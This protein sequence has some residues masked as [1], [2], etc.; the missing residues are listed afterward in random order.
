MDGIEFFQMPDAECGNVCEMEDKLMPKRLCGGKKAYAAYEV[1]SI[2]SVEK[3]LYGGQEDKVRIGSSHGP[4]FTRG[5][6]WPKGQKPTKE[7][8]K[9]ISYGPV[10]LKDVGHI[11][12]D[13]FM[14]VSTEALWSSSVKGRGD[15]RIMKS[16]GANTVR[17]YGDDPRLDHGK[18][19]DEAMREG[20]QVIVGISDYPYTQA[21]DNCLSTNSNC[22]EQ[23]KA[24]YRMVMRKGFL[25]TGN[26]YHPA[27]RTVILMNE[28]DLKFPEGPSSYVKGIVSALDAVLDVEQEFGVVGSAPS[29]TTTFSFGVC[30]GGCPEM[31][32]KPALGQM[33]YL[34]EAMR[35]PHSVGYEPRN[36]LWK[37]YKERFINSVNTANPA[38]DIRWLF[39]NDYDQQFPDT[40][41]FIGEYHSPRTVDQRRDLESV[42]AIARDNKTMLIG[43]SFFEFQVRYDKGGAEE[44]FGMFGL[45]KKSVADFHIEDEHYDAFC[46]KPVAMK[47]VAQDMWKNQ[48]GS[49]EFGVD[50]ITESTWSRNFDRIPTPEFCC[51]E[52]AKHEECKSWTWVE[53][54]GLGGVGSPAQCWLKGGLPVGKAPKDGVISGIPGA[55][56]DPHITKQALWNQCGG[57]Y[58]DGPTECG[59]GRCVEKNEWYS[60]CLPAEG[61]TKMLSLPG[62]PQEDTKLPNIYVHAALTEAYGGEGVAA[63][64]LCPNFSTTT[65]VTTTRL[66]SKAPATSET[67]SAAP[68]DASSEEGDKE[69]SDEE[70]TAEGAEDADT[71][72]VGKES[73]SKETDVGE[74][75][76]SKE[77]SSTDMSTSTAMA[78]ETSKEEE[79]ERGAS[80]DGE[81]YGCF[82]KI[83]DANVVYSNEQ[84]G[85]DSAA[86]VDGC[87]DFGY[88][89]LH[90][91]G[92]CSCGENGPESSN[93]K[94][95][96]DWLCRPVCA[97]EEGQTPERLCGGFDTFA[98]YTTK[99][100]V[101]LSV[102]LSKKRLA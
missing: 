56:Q 82:K 49:V 94:K 30:G 13:D 88:A 12:D 71:D 84:G 70:A 102:R 96:D 35:D 4:T 89:F 17:L 3:A 7:I 83:Q 45:D 101:E 75:S 1:Q 9:G 65:T 93:F 36:D 50:F 54:A 85:F 25:S 86:C 95:V 60:Q 99:N 97:S 47:D 39:L 28:P 5:G 18:F 46:L 38:T 10:P 98:V 61:D 2:A 26:V 55:Q 78:S 43:I 68:A 34:R 24:Q 22:Y 20:V 14:S 23:V 58:W 69:S 53:D 51:D 8:L 66:T 100:M 19:L 72:K 63:R 76:V 6:A 27:L 90:N 32:E 52:C 40:P 42:L 29:F 33:L 16:L 91:S 67:T 41:V 79:V 73:V 15:L 62:A 74:E 11:A 48:C 81:W 92:H 80:G 64:D 77:T 87:R 59:R 21:P 44:C 57:K 31:N 37:A